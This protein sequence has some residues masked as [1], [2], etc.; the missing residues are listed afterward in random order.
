MRN[1]LVL[2]A[3]V[4]CGL[5]M[6]SGCGPA[7]APR[8]PVSGKVSYKGQP[9]PSGTVAF[10]NENTV[11]TGQIQNGQ[12]SIP[13]A[14]VG[15]NKVSVTTPPPSVGQEMQMKQKV[16]GKTFSGEATKPV[17]IPAKYNNP[18]GS[19]LTYTVTAD[20]NQ[21]YDIELKD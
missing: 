14:A 20:K 21:T 3:I 4:S 18:E 12:Y 16:E 8:A 7:A 6:T 19:G 1:V 10:V 2:F 13:N 9:L 5:L 17:A 11:A 15:S